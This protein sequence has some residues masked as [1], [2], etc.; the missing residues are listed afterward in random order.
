[1]TRNR[2]QMFAV[3][4][5]AA[6]FV[7]AGAFGQT[8]TAPATVLCRDGTSVQRAEGACADHGG[9]AG[10]MSPSDSSS[11]A[12]ESDRGTGGSAATGGSPATGGST[13]TGTSIGTGGSA[14]TGA[15][16][17]AGNSAT[18]NSAADIQSNQQP[19]G[20]PVPYAQDTSSSSMP[21]SPSGTQTETPDTTQTATQDT[22]TTAPSS[23][24]P[25]GT[26]AKATA[27]CK[28]GTL[29]YGALAEGACSAHGGVDQW[30]DQRQ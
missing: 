6:A 11:T 1:M 28:D 27:Q 14:A 25:S 16:T 17:A 8:T 5:A 10:P 13:E 7:G 18:G 21:A 4:L 3:V 29:W 24:P 19:S 12:A 22:T 9:V 2:I 23:A 26:P 20:A 30:L 15:S